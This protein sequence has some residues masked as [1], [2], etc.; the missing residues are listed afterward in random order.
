MYGRIVAF[1]WVTCPLTAVARETAS[2][3]RNAQDAGKAAVTAFLERSHIVSNDGAAASAQ[4][5]NGPMLMNLTV[6]SVQGLP[7]RSQH[8]NRYTET[9][10]WLNEYPIFERAIVV[11]KPKEPEPLHRSHGPEL[12]VAALVGAASVLIGL[13]ICT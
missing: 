2:V 10:D 4:R 3:P 11:Q 5:P 9:S 8:V 13:A 1:A 6:M 12:T 7:V